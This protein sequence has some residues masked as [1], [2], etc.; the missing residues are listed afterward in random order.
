MTIDEAYRFVQFIYNKS[1]NGNI[2]PA[3][4]NTLALIAQMSVINEMIGNEQEYQPGRPVPRYGFGLSQKIQEDLRPIIITPTTLTFSSGVA[5]YPINSLY[6]FDLSENSSGAEI[7]PCEVD[8]GRIL[9]G[10]V[11]KPPIVGNAK[12]FVLGASMYVLPSTI[13]DTRVT[14]VRR[15]LAPLWNFDYQNS[16]P[17][18]QPTGSQ[19]FELGELLHLRICLKILQAV[20]INLDLAQ[21]TQAAMAMEAQGA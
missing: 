12:Y 16:V 3:D 21:V 10:S 13:I 5:I 18:F 14:Y 15:P 2:K 4:F 11:I 8:E 19:D 17:V 7:R 6:L 1:Q 20:G 9:S